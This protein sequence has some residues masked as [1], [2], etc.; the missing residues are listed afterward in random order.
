MEVISLQNSAKFD[1][2]KTHSLR[3]TTIKY[4]NTISQNDLSKSIEDLK[5]WFL[6]FSGSTLNGD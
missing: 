3:N 4:N 2:R 6:T 5:K 1:I